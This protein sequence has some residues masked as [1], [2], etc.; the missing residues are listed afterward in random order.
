[1]TAAREARYVSSVDSSPPLPRRSAA[2]LTR[3]VDFDALPRDDLRARGGGARG[4]ARDDLASWTPRKGT[5]SRV[6]AILRPDAAAAARQGIAGWV[7]DRRVG[8]QRDA[9]KDQRFDPSV[10]QAPRATRHDPSSRVPPIRAED[11]AH[12]AAPSRCS[13]A[14][15]GAFDDD[16]ER[17]LQ[18][19]SPAARTCVLVT[20]L[21][22]ARGTIRPPLR[23]RST[24]S[25]SAGAP[26]SAPSTSASRSRRRPTPPCS[27][28]ARPAPARTPLSRAIHV[29]S[30][31]Q[32]GPFVTVDCTTLPIQLVESELFGHERGA[33]TGADRRVPGR[34]SSRRAAAPSST[35][36]A[37]YRTTPR[38]SSCASSRSAMFRA[39]AVARPDPPSTYASCARH[40]RTSRRVEDG[41]REDLYYR[42]RVVRIELPP[43]VRGERDRAA[44]DPFWPTPTRSAMAV[45][46]PSSRPRP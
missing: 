4:G 11:D 22:P 45:P 21:R 31:R 46:L 28:A 15:D 34:W 30:G 23:G 19:R 42:I 20:T 26:S 24:A 40:T 3:E 44:R 5:S 43:R 12:S 33:F 36:S 29:S 18:A 35:R 13:I 39:G 32:A 38:A 25:K 1:M 6:V 7:A 16:D 41:F 8:A 37:I 17:Y 9:A 14:N 27:S 10:G 2:L